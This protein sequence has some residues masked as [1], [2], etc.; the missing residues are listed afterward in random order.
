MP[1]ITRKAFGALTPAALIAVFAAA[2]LP[3]TSGATPVGTQDV[4]V[5][6]TLSC[7]LDNGLLGTDPI[8]TTLSG[9]APVSVNPGDTVELTNVSS[10]LAVPAALDSSLSSLGVL[11]ASGS[12]TTFNIDVTGDSN[13]VVNA[14]NPALAFGP[15]A[16]STAALTLPIPP[17]GTFSVD[18][19]TATGA[20]GTSAVASIGTAT[21]GIVASLNGQ[22][23]S[24]TIGPIPIDCTA[25]T[26]AV[27][28][29]TIN[30]VAPVT[31]TTTTTPTTTTTTTVPTTTTTTTVPTTTT[32]TTTKPTTTTTTTEPTTTTTTTTKPT[33]TTTTTTTHPTTTTTTTTTSTTTTAPA[34]L[35][36]DFKNWTLSGSLTDK[37]LGQKIT[38]PSGATFN[39]SATLPGALTGNILVPKF[40]ATVSILGLKTTVGLSFTENGPVTGTIEADPTTAG[41]L[42]VVGTAKAT[43]GISSV[44]L[45]GINIPTSCQTSSP[46]SFPLSADLPALDLTTGAT[47]TG[48]T[49][50]PSVKCGG[51]LG[52]LLSPILTLLFSGPGNTYSLTIAP[53]AS[54][55]SAS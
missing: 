7:E 34:G 19:G 6:V 42:D 41:N 36:I 4:T 37:T 52:G 46:V 18:L 43:I 44:G 54:S 28:L 25:P 9:Q 11:S 38:L 13:T 17:T 45:F 53:P 26:P 14:A 55:S 2:A 50:L 30:I 40:S 1:S 3:A 15:V 16:V 33:T 39:G 23:A 48:T 5:S 12:V 29:G 24:S 35:T 22:E 32:T 49:T 31:T 47:F 27:A 51:I 21:D 8:P 10:S 20:P